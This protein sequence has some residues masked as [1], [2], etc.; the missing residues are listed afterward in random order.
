MSDE[1]NS[2]TLYK[3]CRYRDVCLR[4]LGENPK[5]WID[6]LVTPCPCGQEFFRQVLSYA[7]VCEYERENRVL[8]ESRSYV[9]HQMTQKIPCTPRPKRIEIPITQSRLDI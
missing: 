9:V 3:T 5:Q 4:Y 6:A 8:F 2:T 1:Y 7:R